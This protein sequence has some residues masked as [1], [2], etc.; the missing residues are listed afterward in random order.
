MTHSLL[1]MSQSSLLD[2]IERNQQHPLQRNRYCWTEPDIDWP[3]HIYVNGSNSSTAC[4]DPLAEPGG[5]NLIMPNVER[6]R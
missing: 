5:L 3:E 6:L 4:S 2:N 1:S